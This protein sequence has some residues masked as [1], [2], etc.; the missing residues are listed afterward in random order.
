MNLCHAQNPAAEKGK[1]VVD[2]LNA[3]LQNAK[4]DT[5][6][7]RLLNE[8]CIASPVEEHLKY[9]RQMVEMTDKILSQ[10]LNAEERKNILKKK[11]KG[12]GFIAFY[13]TQDST[14]DSSKAIGFAQMGIKVAEE[15]GDKKEVA[16]AFSLI[17]GVYI[18]LH[19][20]SKTIESDMEGLRILDEAL[21]DSKGKDT[22][23]IQ[24]KLAVLSWLADDYNFINFDS[25][26]SYLQQAVLFCIKNKA[27]LT[28]IAELNSL[29]ALAQGYWWVGNYSEAKEAYLKALQKAESLHDT[30]TI[31]WM[32][33][34][35]EMVERYSGNYRA[36]LNYSSKAIELTKNF[37]DNDALNEALI[38]KGLTYMELDILDSAFTYA[39]E[40]AAMQF[41]KNRGKVQWGGL[42]EVMGS[43]YSKMG[44]AKLAEEYFR[45]SLQTSEKVF[46]WRMLA[47][48]SCEFAKHFERNIQLDSAIFYATKASA[49][50]S[51][52][53]FYVLQVRASGLLAKLYKQKNNTDSAYKYLE[54]MITTKDKVFSSEKIARMQ[55]LEINEQYRQQELDAA[56]KTGEEERKQNLQFV[57]M[58]I[59]I[60]TFIILFFMLSRSIIANERWIS[61][62]GILGLLIVFEFVNLLIHPLLEKK[63][64][65]SPIL[66]LV[67]LVIIASLLIPLHHR[68]EKWIKEKMTEKNKAI[69]LANA[70][71]TI[72]KLEV[73]PTQTQSENTN[74]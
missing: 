51:R 7:L 3:E 25:V 32:Y 41:R 61:F 34:G 53:N 73:K 12:Y 20:S 33:N 27:S 14:L 70:K 40:A 45:Q 62:L 63:T 58:A 43:I 8:L 59:G 39:Q 44:N 65:H 2:S 24:M 50:D 55:T 49:L 36:A 35:L 13:Y 46:D 21:Q 28:P 60:V 9:G 26:I 16:K 71:K 19:N 52:Y 22:V 68:M 11:A 47:R 64:N 42:Q 18:D 54:L 67:V 15:T 66:M 23:A 5:T 4:Q 10:H 1:R 29:K 74:V 72:E 30:L 37:P 6:R 17:G 38:D 57:L 31:G 48:S 69:R 56:R